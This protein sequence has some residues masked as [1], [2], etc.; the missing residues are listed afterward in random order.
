MQAEAFKKML[1]HSKSNLLVQVIVAVHDVSDLSL[2]KQAQ[3][4]IQIELAFLLDKYVTRFGQVIINV[5]D[6]R[7]VS[8]FIDVEAFN[9]ATASQFVNQIMNERVAV[10][11]R[12]MTI[13]QNTLP[14]STIALLEAFLDENTRMDSLPYTLAIS[15]IPSM[16]ESGEEFIDPTVFFVYDNR[17]KTVQLIRGLGDEFVNKT[18]RFRLM[19][20]RQLTRQDNGLSKTYDFRLVGF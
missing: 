17:N 11:N 15:S 16:K 13:K 2:S 12:Y 8:K 3:I 20:T 14:G 9:K 7:P 4:F 10:D 1:Q 5:I 19:D 6:N 18:I